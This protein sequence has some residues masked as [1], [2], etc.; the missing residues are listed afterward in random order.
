MNLTEKSELNTHR[1]DSP[2]QL[3]HESWVELFSVNLQSLEER[4]ARICEAVIS[5]KEGVILINQ[6][7]KKLFVFFFFLFNLYVFIVTQEDLYLV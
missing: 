5:A 1:C 4:N 3:L 2:Q 6:H 7:F